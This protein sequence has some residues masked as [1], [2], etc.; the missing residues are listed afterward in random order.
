MRYAAS[1]TAVASTVRMPMNAEPLNT[2]DM[3]AA[4]APEEPHDRIGVLLRTTREAKRLALTDVARTLRIRAHYL[5]AIEDGHYERLPAAVYA[6]GFIRGYAEYLQLDGEEAIRRFRRE[7]QTVDS[8]PDLSYPVPIA[9]RSI[10]GGRILVTALVLAICGYGLWYYAVDG[11]RQ[12]ANPVPEVPTALVHN[13]AEPGV[14]DPLASPSEARASVRVPPNAAPPAVP[15]AKP[16]ALT[17]AS[18][19]SAPAPATVMPS[20]ALPEPGLRAAGAQA[21]ASS[22]TASRSSGDMAAQQVALIGPPTPPPPKP[23]VPIAGPSRVYGTT[24]GPVHIVVRIT[25]DCWIEVR[26]ADDSLRFSKLLHAGDEYRVA[27][28][29]GL[30]LKTGNSNG[31]QILVDGKPVNVP[32]VDS[33]VYTVALDPQRLAAGDAAVPAEIHPISVPRHP[34]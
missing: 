18:P 32:P 24:D 33:R 7:T 27:D 23:S 26:E 17:A 28:L 3:A 22:P 12:Q 9:E 16:A 11:G 19:P 6:A 10:P 4:L 13:G 2:S 20:A 21:D 5:E 1:D 8:Q 15:A 34:D 14:P 30:T 31:L 25:G 29:P